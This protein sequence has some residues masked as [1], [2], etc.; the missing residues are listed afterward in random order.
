MNLGYV[1]MALGPFRFG[2]NN[3]AFQDYK[4]TAEFIWSEVDRVRREPDLQYAGPASQTIKISGVIYPQFRGGI[5]QTELMRI[6]GG[7]GAR[8]PL[9]DG[10]GWFWQQWV[11]TGVDDT[12]KLFLPNGKPRE[13]QFTLSLKAKPRGLL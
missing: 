12:R 13:I 6:Q 7:L 2:I 5:H 4:K 10:F 11:I 1:M 9:T 8:L 3:G